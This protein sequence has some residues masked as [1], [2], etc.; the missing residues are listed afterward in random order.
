MM[1][2]TVRAV[3]EEYQ[4][5]LNEESKV[6]KFDLKSYVESRDNYLPGIGAETGKFLNILIKCHRPQLIV[7]VGTSYGYSPLWLAE[8]AQAGRAKLVTLKLSLDKVAARRMG[9]SSDGL[10]LNRSIE[11]PRSWFRPE[12]KIMLDV[13]NVREIAEI[14]IN[15]KPLGVPW[16][17]LYRADATA[18]L[19]PGLNHIEMKVTNL[20]ANRI[21][22]D[23]QPNAMTTYT[24][25]DVRAYQA[26][27][28]LPESGLLGPVSI[29]AETPRI[30]ARIGA[31][32]DSETASW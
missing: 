23:Q 7:E 1:D 3:L 26:N 13:G 22:G 20:R 18:A 25:T 17:P 9:D 11:A 6:G 4:S 12:T 28:P 19:K 14:S 21:I 8:A 29:V 32:S 24:F 5:S 31:M 10:Q 30:H 2:N 27:S 16:K 15:D